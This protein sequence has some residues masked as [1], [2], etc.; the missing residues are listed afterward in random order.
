[1]NDKIVVAILIGA[2]LIA[3]I[4]GVLYFFTDIFQSSAPSDS[5]PATNTTTNAT[6][7]AATNTNSSAATADDEMAV[8]NIEMQTITGTGSPTPLVNAPISG[9]EPLESEADVDAAIQ[10]NF[11]VDPATLDMTFDEKVDLLEDFYDYDQDGLL[12]M[13]EEEYGTNMMKADTDGDGYTDI[14]EIKGCYSPIE[15]GAVMD[16]NYYEAGYC[17]DALNAALL[18]PEADDPYVYTDGFLPLCEYW[19]PFAGQIFDAQRSDTGADLADFYSSDNEL[20]ATACEQT[21]ALYGSD[22]LFETT[23]NYVEKADLTPE[24]FCGW[25]SSSIKFIC[26]PQNF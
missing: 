9:T 4:G 3:A 26:S 24:E 18:Q 17:F 7:N 8:T 12:N 22:E 21:Q 13:Y 14:E 25:W 2:V 11:G 10:E 20:Y 1:M 16:A 5:S 19:A 23:L 6:T 15:A